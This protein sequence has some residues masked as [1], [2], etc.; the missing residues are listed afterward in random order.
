MT[1]KIDIDHVKKATPG[2]TKKN[3]LLQHLSIFLNNLYKHVTNMIDINVIYLKI[4][5]PLQNMN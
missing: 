1:P 3:N 5:V 2:S 4:K